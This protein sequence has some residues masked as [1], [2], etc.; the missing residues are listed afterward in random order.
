MINAYY[1][2]IKFYIRILCSSWLFMTKNLNLQCR[3]NTTQTKT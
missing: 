2:Y 3:E 1:T